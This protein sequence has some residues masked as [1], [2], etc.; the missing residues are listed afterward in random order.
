M[1]VRKNSTKVPW[2][3]TLRF[4]GW[5]E[6]NPSVTWGVGLLRKAL[7]VS[8]CTGQMQHLFL[9][10][11]ARMHLHP[12]HRCSRSWACC[13]GQ[14][15]PKNIAVSSKC[16]C[17]GCCLGFW[18]AAAVQWMMTTPREQQAR[19]HARIWFRWFKQ[20]D[21]PSSNISEIALLSFGWKSL[22]LK[23][24]VALETAVMK[25]N[26]GRNQAIDIIYLA[27]SLD[28][29][30]ELLS[31]PCSLLKPTEED[32]VMR[33]T[34]ILLP[35]SKKRKEKDEKCYMQ[36]HH[37]TIFASCVCAFSPFILKSA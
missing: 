11:D 8:C 36:S 1:W 3:V 16:H 27:D 20:T 25:S 37:P 13:L 28:M 12:L 7:Y 31:S 26:W 22:K 33:N 10:M 32:V 19:W 24:T 14:A 5:Q 18:T 15:L 2:G 21:L 34:V 6:S 35:N 23:L 4:A 29:F 30:C 17:L 9:S